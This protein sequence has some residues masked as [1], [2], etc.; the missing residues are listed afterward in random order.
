SEQMFTALRMLGREAELVR[1]YGENHGINSKPS[2]TRNL[3]GVMLD[4]Y[5][6]WLRGQ[7]AAWNARWADG[8]VEHA[9]ADGGGPG[10]DP[11]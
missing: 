8:G 3:Y 7:G 2:I 11:R 9:A 6:R 4:W 5:D 10:P 1:F